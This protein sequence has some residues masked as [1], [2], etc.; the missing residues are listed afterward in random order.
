MMRTASS[1]RAAT[2]SQSIQ[3]HHDAADSILMMPLPQCP[4]TAAALAPCRPNAP[5]T[6]TARQQPQQ[7]P[8]AAPDMS[9]STLPPRTVT[10]PNSAPKSQLRQTPKRMPLAPSCRSC[11]TI[12]LLHYNLEPVWFSVIWEISARTVSSTSNSSPKQHLHHHPK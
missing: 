7:H 11:K 8:N 12:P 9:P 2:T 3:P 6:D 4:Q 10:S 1:L 5:V